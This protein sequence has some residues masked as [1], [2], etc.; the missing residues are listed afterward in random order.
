MFFIHWDNYVLPDSNIAPT[1]S[2]CMVMGYSTT[3]PIKNKIAQTNSI[4]QHT[5]VIAEYSASI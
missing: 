2:T 4:L 1:F 3:S 5:S